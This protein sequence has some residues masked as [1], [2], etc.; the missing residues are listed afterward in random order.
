MSRGLK[1]ASLAGVVLS[2]LTCREP[3]QP[4]PAAASLLGG[5]PV[6]TSLLACAPLPQDSVTQVVGVDG[7]TLTA[8]PHTL[9]I[10]AGALAG[11][12]SITAVAPSEQVSRVR[13]HPEGLVF[14][15]P[16]ALTL[17]YAHCEWSGLLPRSVAHTTD[18]LAILQVLPSVD[19]PGARKVTGELRH[20]SS[21]AVAW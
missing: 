5:L 11:P 17:S 1:A 12:V 20:F 6:G 10:P 16:V 8:G 3:A 21:Y 14:Q 15:E 7:G 4:D 9:V 13:F 2:A 19:D 18:A